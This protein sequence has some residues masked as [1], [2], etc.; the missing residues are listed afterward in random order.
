MNNLPDFIFNNKQRRIFFLT[1]LCMFVM[2]TLH[3]IGVRIGPIASPLPQKEDMLFNILP[4]LQK[5]ND[6]FSVKKQQQIIPQAH[7]ATEVDD[8]AAYG[9][10]DYQTGDVIL[11]KNLD[12]KVSIASITKVMTV[13]V[14]LD[15]ADPQEK[16]EVTQNAASQIP[17]KIGVK[18]GEKFTLEELINAAMLTSANDAVEVIRDGIDAKYEK[19]IFIKAMN[20]KARIIGLKNTRFENPQGFDGQEHYSTVEDLALL[21]HYALTNYPL[22]AE[23]SAKDY[24]FL[25]KNEDHK[26]YDLYNWN[27]LIGVYPGATG[28][29]IGNTGDAGKTTVVTA[30]RAGKEMIAVVLGAPG[31]RERDMWAAQ[32]LDEGFSTA[33]GLEKVEVTSEDLQAKYDSWQFWN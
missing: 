23:V 29:K 10:I 9:V 11:E 30:N 21:T 27:G 19:G 28:V 31:I 13:V 6:T 16:F 12:K 14:A 5:H 25:P 24:E 8:A 32:L 20:E 15:L 1:F 17:T 26:Q 22:I 3:N 18:V 33:Y 2:V 4:K 7:A